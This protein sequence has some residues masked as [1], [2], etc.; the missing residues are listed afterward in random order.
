MGE[1]GYDPE[2]FGFASEMVS[3]INAKERNSPEPEM[4]GMSNIWDLS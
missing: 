1:T 4:N 3:A 2:V